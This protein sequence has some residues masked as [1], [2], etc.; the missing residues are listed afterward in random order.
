MVV[1]WAAES[2]GLTAPKAQLFNVP[3]TSVQVYA[4]VVSE[5][6]STAASLTSAQC[7][8]L[9]FHTAF[10]VSRCGV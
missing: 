3:G 7:T 2:H 1:G 9:R 5:D 8:V 10:G 6:P 4:R